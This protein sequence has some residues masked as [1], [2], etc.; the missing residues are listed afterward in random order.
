MGA[1]DDGDAG[2]RLPFYEIEF[3]GLRRG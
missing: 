3:G 2:I 1:A